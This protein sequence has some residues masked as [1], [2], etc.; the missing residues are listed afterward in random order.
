MQSDIIVD[1]QVAA[2]MM[3]GSTQR[4]EAGALI[5]AFT[6]PFVILALYHLWRL[7]EPAGRRYATL[8]IATLFV[9]FTWSPL[10]HASF[11]FVGEACKVAVQMDGANASLVLGMAQS[12]I[13]VVY[14]TWFPAIGLTALGWL[15]VSIALLRGKTALPRFFGLLTPLPVSLLFIVIYYLVP[16]VV[17]DLLAGAGFNLAAIVFYVST[18]VFCF[19]HTRGATVDSGSGA[20]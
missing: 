4:L 18:T 13:D 12:F 6:I 16:S 17:P 2:A 9:A 7:M 19:R 11:F 1:K 14:L 8:S 20:S 15:F 10:A 3:E 5:A